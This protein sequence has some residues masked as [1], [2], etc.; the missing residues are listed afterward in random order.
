M[1]TFT[2][3]RLDILFFHSFVW[4]I[5]NFHSHETFFG[6]VLFHIMNPLAIN[7]ISHSIYIHNFK[8]TPRYSS[9]PS[10]QWSWKKVFLPYHN[11]QN[12]GRTIDRTIWQNNYG[13]SIWQNNWQNY[14]YHITIGRT[15]LQS[16]LESSPIHQ[17]NALSGPYPVP[18]QKCTSISPLSFPISTRQYPKPIQYTGVSTL[19]HL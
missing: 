19:T 10:Q 18:V 12:Y 6:V 5:S 17:A 15:K 7:F 1:T 8:V 16:F 13:R 14:L 9:D 4:R 11:W 3:P 2:C